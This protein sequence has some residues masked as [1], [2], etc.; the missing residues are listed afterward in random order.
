MPLIALFKQ[1]HLTMSYFSERTD[2]ILN[3]CK[4]I[5]LSVLHGYFSEKIK[6]D[7]TVQSSSFK[8]TDLFILTLIIK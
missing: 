8:V 4:N 3:Q 6:S 7:I 1:N 5:F 2:R